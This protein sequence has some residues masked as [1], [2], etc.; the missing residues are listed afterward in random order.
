MT[1]L[2]STVGCF[3]AISSPLVAAAGA[4]FTA[5]VPVLGDAGVVI[6]TL[7]LAAFGVRYLKSRK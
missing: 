7:G 4:P 1:F 3:L 5:P 6:L 2:K